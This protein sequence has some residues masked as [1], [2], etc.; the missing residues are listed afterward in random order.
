M[1][2]LHLPLIK[3]VKDMSHGTTLKIALGALQGLHDQSGKIFCMTLLSQVHTDCLNACA[4]EWG[5]STRFVDVVGADYHEVR[6]T[7]DSSQN[8]FEGWPYTMND[9]FLGQTATNASATDDFL[10]LQQ[11]VMTMAHNPDVWNACYGG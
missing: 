7:C 9:G 5:L 2:C 1:L 4:S 6:R 8:C 11:A 3:P 10:V